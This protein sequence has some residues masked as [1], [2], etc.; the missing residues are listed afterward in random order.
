[1][2]CIGQ[3]LLHWMWTVLHVNLRRDQPLS[4]NKYMGSMLVHM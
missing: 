4:F 2:L 1:M 3:L